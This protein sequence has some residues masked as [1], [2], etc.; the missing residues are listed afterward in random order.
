MPAVPCD[1]QVASAVLN[2]GKVYIKEPASETHGGK[3]MNMGPMDCKLQIQY[4]VHFV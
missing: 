4:F 3:F 2:E 1:V